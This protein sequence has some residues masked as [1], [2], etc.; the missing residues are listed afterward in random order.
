MIFRRTNPVYIGGHKCYSCELI[1]VRI[2]RE[3]LGIDQRGCRPSEH[4]D[5][6][7][8]FVQVVR[9]QNLQQ[10]SLQQILPPRWVLAYRIS[11]IN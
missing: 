8:N 7:E 1:M 11:R 4:S 2:G 10:I 9:I 5:E 3:C 6:P